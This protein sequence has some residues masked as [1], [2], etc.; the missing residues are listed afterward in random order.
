MNLT[1]VKNSSGL[2]NC[3]TFYNN[4]TSSILFFRKY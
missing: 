3:Q 2:T 1:T 4:P